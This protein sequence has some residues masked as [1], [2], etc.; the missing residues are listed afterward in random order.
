M[1]YQPGLSLRLPVPAR[2]AFVCLDGNNCPYEPAPK[3]RA[4]VMEALS[5][6]WM[7]EY[8]EYREVQLIE[9]ASEFYGVPSTCIAVTAGVDHA[10]NWLMWLASQNKAFVE[11]HLITYS[12]FIDQADRYGVN[13]IG[14]PQKPFDPHL[15]YFHFESDF[16][17]VANPNNPTGVLFDREEIIWYLNRGKHMIVD[18]SYMDWA[19]TDQSCAHM[20][21]KNSHLIVLR[22]FSKAFALAGMRVG[23]MFA[24]PELIEKYK[25]TFDCR[26]IPTF[27]Q[28]AVETALDNYDYVKEQ[29]RFARITKENALGILQH[30]GF[31]A[32][33]THTNFIL[34]ADDHATEVQAELDNRY[35]ILT[36]TFSNWPGYLRVSVGS[37]MDM[38]RFCYKYVE[39]KD[40]PGKVSGETVIP[41]TASE[42]VEVNR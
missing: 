17:Y 13:L 36:R 12:G 38:E 28:I 25:N 15:G 2:S 4:A 9:R 26:L 37:G 3:V 34:I 35:R 41:Q 19:E 7:R 29:I 5:K 32:I 40:K 31:Q 11:H 16:T 18:E 42:D 8:P 39:I 22:G 24:N 23:L 20:I 1:T 33:D 30:N 14:I 6:G 27:T 10:L 21:P